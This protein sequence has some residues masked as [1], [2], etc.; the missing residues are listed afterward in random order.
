[1]PEPLRQ[2]ATF[3]LLRVIPRTED[4]H[5]DPVAYWDARTSGNDAR[6]ALCIAAGIPTDLIDPAVGV[7]P[8]APEGSSMFLTYLT[9]NAAYAVTFGDSIVPIGGHHLHET[10]QVAAARLAPLGL[11]LS[12]DEVVTVGPNPAD[13]AA[14]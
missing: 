11:G 12:G 2:R 1:M 7:G 8:I 14:A 3:R 4:R 6:A 5:R 13:K 10:R 9:A